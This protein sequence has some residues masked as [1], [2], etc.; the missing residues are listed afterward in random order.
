MA[1]VFVAGFVADFAADFVVE[2]ADLV[3]EIHMEEGGIDQGVVEIHV[4][5]ED[6]NLEGHQMGTF[7]GS[8]DRGGHL[9]P[10]L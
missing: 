6:T 8:L 1:K 10:I 7:L 9:Y 4:Q 3:V 5:V 2:I